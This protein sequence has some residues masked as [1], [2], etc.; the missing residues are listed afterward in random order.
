[1]NTDFL[2]CSLLLALICVYPRL[3]FWFVKNISG[4]IYEPFEYTGNINNLEDVMIFPV[5]EHVSFISRVM[6]LMPGDVIFT[7]TPEGVGPMVKGDVAEV[8]VE[9]SGGLQ[10]KLL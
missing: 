6:T 8:L 7:G 9:G 5:F 10:N 3:Y 2:R 1:M 4:N